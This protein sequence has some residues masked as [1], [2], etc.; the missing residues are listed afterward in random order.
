VERVEQLYQSNYSKE[1]DLWACF[2]VANG[3]CFNIHVRDK[4]TL[5]T[6]T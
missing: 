1:D 5:P 4:P 2:E 6:S 3:E